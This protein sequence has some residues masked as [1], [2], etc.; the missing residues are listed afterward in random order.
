MYDQSGISQ[1]QFEKESID[2]S[3]GSIQFGDDDDNLS[4]SS[5]VPSCTRT[6]TQ[7]GW[8]L[9]IQMQLCPSKF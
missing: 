2:Q 6:D 5:V 3:A 4:M 1:I 8:T 9:F 7:S